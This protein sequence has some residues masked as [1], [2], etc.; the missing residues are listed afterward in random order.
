LAVVAVAVAAEYK[1]Y[2]P[3]YKP[4]YSKPAYSAY[5]DEYAYVSPE[6]TNLQI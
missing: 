4:A 5:K 6:I 2:E 3:A 1:S